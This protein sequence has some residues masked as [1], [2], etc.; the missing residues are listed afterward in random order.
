MRKFTTDEEMEAIF[1][2]ID[3]MTD[4][5]LQ[6][7]AEAIM[8]EVEAD[9]ELK[10]KMA[11]LP[12]DFFDKMHEELLAK[13]KQKEFEEGCLRLLDFVFKK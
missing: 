11:E 12:P 3:G 9:E 4:E 13:I 8:A 7:E 5:E 6:A 2:K 1:K 10:A